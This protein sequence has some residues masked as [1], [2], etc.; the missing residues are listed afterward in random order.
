M[1]NPVSYNKSTELI[2]KDNINKKIDVVIGKSVYHVDFKRYTCSCINFKKNSYCKHLDIVCEYLSDSINKNRNPIENLNYKTFNDNYMYKNNLKEFM[3][4][5]SQNKNMSMP[6]EYEYEN[7]LNGFNGTFGIEIEYIEGQSDEI[8]KKLYE[9]DLCPHIKMMRKKVTKGYN[10]WKVEID[11]SVT[12]GRLG[13]EIISPILVDNP[14]TWNEIKLICNVIK[15]YGGKINQDCGMHIHVGIDE[16]KN[17]WVNLFKTLSLY[18]EIIYRY[19]GGDRGC[20]RDSYKNYCSPCNIIDFPISKLKKEKDIKNLIY[21]LMG[22]NDLKNKG[23]NFMNIISNTNKNTVE[24]RYFNGTLNPYIIQS[25]IILVSNIINT[26][27]REEYHNIENDLGTKKKRSN[28]KILSFIDKYFKRK[29]D[30]DRILD[31]LQKNIWRKD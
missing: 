12:N 11:R 8:A 21:K 16:M 7:V 9:L 30:K 13:G 19:A 27:I 1:E 10:K 25:N 18:E 29:K 22:R 4:R 2:I 14:Q 31:I 3:S 24:F 15:E 5:I 28:N 26:C 20:I 6:H 23:V 17:G